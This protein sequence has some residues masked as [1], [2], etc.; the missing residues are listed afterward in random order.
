M[1]VETDIRV[2]VPRVRRALGTHAAALADGVVKDIVAD[3]LSDI[4]LY[5]GGAWPTQIVVTAYQNGSPSEYATSDALTLPQGS[6]VAA[7]AA[8]NYFFNT[9]AE[10]KVSERIS[11]ER[12]S[13]EWARSASLLVEQLKQLRAARDAALEQVATDTG[14]GFDEYRSLLAIRDEATSRAIEPY[15]WPGGVGGMSFG[16]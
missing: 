5:S 15:T 14:A 13:W 10:Q 11:D 1:A 6:V 16:A 12:T 4:I 3:A 7:Q 9:W 8:L 2:L